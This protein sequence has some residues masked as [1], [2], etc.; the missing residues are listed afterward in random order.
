MKVLHVIPSVGP[1]R[2]GPS[3]VV[4]EIARGLAAQG[5]HVE[6]AATDDNGPARLRIAGQAATEDG[7]TIRYFPRQSRFYSV[8]LPL[9]RWLR[10]HAG[11]FD[12]VHI[13]ALFSFPST[14][15]ALCCLARGVPYIV[16][17]LGTLNEWGR[18]HRRPWLKRLS[19]LMLER[20]ILNHAAAIQFTTEQERREAAAI[21]PR[22]TPLIVP[23]PVPE[24]RESPPYGSFRA[25]H[26]EIGDRPLI[27]FL[28][29]LDEKKGLDLLLEAYAEV[30]KSNPASALVIA[31]DGPAR[32]V[33]E[34]QRRA[35]S[36]GIEDRVIWTGFVSGQEKSALL[37][38]ADVFVLPSY[39]ENFGVAVVEAMGAGLPVIVSDQ[40]GIH[41]E[42]SRERAGTV[43]P[44][45]AGRLASAITSLLAD[46]DLRARMGQHGRALARQFA[47]AAVATQI[48]LSYA[49]I[50]N[51]LREPVAV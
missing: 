32:F 43:V 6:I 28:S 50:C 25:A 46:P 3:F 40:V 13:H 29:R 22:A 34:I 30:R 26:P 21:A 8:S 37:R 42:V 4:R 17:P 11:D 20:R 24:P 27:L 38:D 9:F 1:L 16:R 14:A 41:H 47:P 33:R 35:V 51:K 12:I 48:L 44:C 36:L 45:A 15:A 23:N 18:A 10:K 39:S 7:Y 2:G 19:I 31:G 49:R 5:V